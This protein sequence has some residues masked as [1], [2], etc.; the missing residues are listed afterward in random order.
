[1]TSCPLLFSS[2]FRFCLYEFGIFITA[3][4]KTCYWDLI[5]IF[6]TAFT[7][8]LNHEATLSPGGIVLPNVLRFDANDLKA[9]TEA[10]ED[11]F[12][13]V[14]ASVYSNAALSLKHWLS[15]NDQACL[16]AENERL[17]QAS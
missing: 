16:V 2:K 13:V 3:L 15:T 6:R 17:R 8:Q 11:F 12:V 7:E 14:V 10:A 1:M 9:A 4:K 5:S